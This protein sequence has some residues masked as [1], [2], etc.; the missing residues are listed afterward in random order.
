MKKAEFVELNMEKAFKWYANKEGLAI[1]EVECFPFFSDLQEVFEYIY[2]DENDSHQES[3]DVIR[4]LATMDIRKVIE[5]ETSTLAEYIA[6]DWERLER[7][8]YGYIAKE[9]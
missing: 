6:L 4:M 1:E 5:S 7:T 3:I 8:P 9:I 2:I